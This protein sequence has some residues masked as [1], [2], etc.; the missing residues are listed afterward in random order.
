MPAEFEIK[1]SAEM[2]NSPGESEKWSQAD[3]GMVVARQ[4]YCLE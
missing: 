4:E 2:R 1:T 3:D